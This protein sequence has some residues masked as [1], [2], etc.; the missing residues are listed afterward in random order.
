MEDGRRD[1]FLAL[2]ALLALYAVLCARG[3]HREAGY[4]EQVVRNHPFQGVLIRLLDFAAGPGVVFLSP[5]CR[6]ALI[7]HPQIVTWAA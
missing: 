5:E 6:E 1:A 2:D 4:I 7:A 3:R